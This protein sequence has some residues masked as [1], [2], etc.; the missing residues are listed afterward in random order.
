MFRSSLSLI[1]IAALSACGG[2]AAAPA[3]DA[4]G[5][6]VSSDGLKLIPLAD[7][8]EFPWGLA[9]L[10]NGDL[11]VTEREGRLRLI[12]SE[13]LVEAP[14]TGLPDDILAEG[15]GGLLGIL[16]DPDFD[17]NRK[18][19]LSYSKGMGETNTTAVISATLNEDAS[20]LSDVTEIFAASPRETTFHYGSRMAFLPDGSL[21][22][23]LGEGYRYMEDSQ[24]LDNL[25]GKIAR[26][27][28]D[29]SIPTDNP[30]AGTE[31]NPA[32]YSYGHRN[33]Q[34]LVYDADRDLLIAHEHGPK[35]GDELNVI[36]PGLNYGWPTITYGINYDG[37]IITDETEAEGMEQPVVKWVPSIAPSGM[38]LVETP[39]FADWQ[40][41]LLVGAMNGPAGLKLVRVDLDESGDVVG[42]EDLLEDLQIAYRD[43]IS[44]PNG[45]FVATADLDGAVYKVALAE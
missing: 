27:M 7:G 25:H 22:V 40:G 8:L 21:I 36:E 11:L 3:P 15:Q 34:G 42:T 38:A 30:F 39:E 16:L 43:V 41:D 6:F 10:P 12:S 35:G 37:T 17:T 1:A 20:G 26:V 31:N 45:I 44:T 28:P 5:A 18:L 32:I 9:E 19:Y 2:E 13:G 24:T 23:T 33:V 14:L 29:G 4:E